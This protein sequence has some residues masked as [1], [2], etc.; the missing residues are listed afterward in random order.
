MA[1][2]LH[3]ATNEIALILEWIVFIIIFIIIF[4][5]YLFYNL[6][7]NKCNNGF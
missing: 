2:Q 1:M 4:H 7:G 3:I 6:N 5:Y